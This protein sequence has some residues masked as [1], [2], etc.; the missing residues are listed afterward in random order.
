MKIHKWKYANT[1]TKTQF[2]QWEGRWEA[3]PESVKF[4]QH[5]FQGSHNFIKMTKIMGLLKTGNE[6]KVF[7]ISANTKLKYL[8]MLLTN[9]QFWR[10]HPNC[11]WCFLLIPIQLISRLPTA[12]L[13]CWYLTQGIRLM[14]LMVC[15]RMV[16]VMTMKM[17]GQMYNIFRVG[18]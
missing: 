15:L 5:T 6:A 18:C 3:W 4:A 13:N 14:K 7:Y 10:R 12:S 9:F 16:M 17:F 11:P 1:N 8:K 2:A